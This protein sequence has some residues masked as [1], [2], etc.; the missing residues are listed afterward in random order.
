MENACRTQ[1]S[2]LSN[3]SVVEVERRKP[4][5]KGVSAFKVSRRGES[6]LATRRSIILLGTEVMEIGR[7]ARG[8]VGSLPGF[9]IGTT[10]AEV[11]I[12]GNFDS[13]QHRFI[14]SRR[15]DRAVG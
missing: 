14:K 9:G 2:N 13:H 7:Y 4:N 8:S 12:A 6:L 3:G 11:Q 10:I 15:K 1:K 5:W